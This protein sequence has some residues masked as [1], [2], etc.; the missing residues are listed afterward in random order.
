MPLPTELHMPA[1]SDLRPNQGALILNIVFN[2]GFPDDDLLRRHFVNLVRLVDLSVAEYETARSHLHASLPSGQNRLGSLLSATDHLEL[3]VITVH[4]ALNALDSVI[5]RPEAPKI[6]RDAR[7]A[8]RAFEGTL[9]GTR[10]AIEHIE[11]RISNGQVQTGQSHALLV[12]QDG[13]TAS[14]GPHQLSLEALG[15]AIRRLH[16][17]VAQT[18]ILHSTTGQQH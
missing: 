4:R 11:E 17:L 16:E 10:H 6:S 5:R 8:L 1:L 15:A 13:K 18:L 7:R 9:S 14:I 3:C 12:S 2:R